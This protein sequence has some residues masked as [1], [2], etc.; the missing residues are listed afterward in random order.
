MQTRRRDQFSTVRTEGP[1]L[2]PDLLRRI[3]DDDKALGGLTPEAYHLGRGE[4]LN[5]VINRSWNRLLGAWATF[6]A[7]TAGS[8]RC[9]RSS[10]MVAYRPPVAS[11][12]T[13][14]TTRSRTPGA[15]S[16][17]ISSEPASTWTS[18]QPASQAPPESA[19]TG[20]S[21]IC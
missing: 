3:A 4:R 2:P 5:E 7:G 10:G 19:R 15:P 13:G 20:S 17:S 18:A 6:R 11:R 8:T 12:L 21:R 16:R 1:I 14:R 9:S